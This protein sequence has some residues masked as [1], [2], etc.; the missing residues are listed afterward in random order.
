[1]KENI[2][3]KPAF[4]YREYQFAD[5]FPIIYMTETEPSSE[6]SFYHFH[7]CIE[8]AFCRQNSKNFII[9]NQELFLSEGDACF[10][11]PYNTHAS[12]KPKRDNLSAHYDYLF[13]NPENLLAP[14]YPNGVPSELLWYKFADAPYLLDGIHFKKELFYLNQIC[15]D[16]QRNAFSVQLSTRGLIQVLMILLSRRFSTTSK[17]SAFTISR[18]A[19]L[20]AVSYMNAHFHED[21]ETG[22]LSE[23]CQLSRSRFRIDFQA[24]VGRTPDQYLRLLRIQNACQ[25]LIK[26]DFT[27]LDIAMS[28]GFRS[29]SAFYHNFRQVTG[30]SPETWRKEKQTFSKKTYLHSSFDQTRDP[31]IRKMS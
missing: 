3:A 7:N 24:A 23:L 22:Q 15:Q 6:I 31:S 30:I 8:I 27:I 11:P 12:Y 14:F 5:D 2:S 19:I 21:I 28:S 20:P 4:I 10:I 9:E 16:L 25:L 29:A 26:T 13:F 17:S 1:M 18:T